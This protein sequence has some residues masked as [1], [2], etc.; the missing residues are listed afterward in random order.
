MLTKLQKSR[1][2]KSLR[3]NWMNL[4]ENSKLTLSKTTMSFISVAASKHFQFTQL[5]FIIFVDTL[6]LTNINILPIKIVMF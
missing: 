5:A 3:Q 2:M 6:K 4:E 1:F